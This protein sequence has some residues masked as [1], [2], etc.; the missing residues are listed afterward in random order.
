MFALALSAALI[1]AAACGSGDSGD[2][3][4]PSPER[5]PIPFT[6]T[7]TPQIKAFQYEIQEGDSLYGL[8]LRFNT[9]LEEIVSLNGINDVEAIGIGEVILIPGDPPPDLPSP[10]VTVIP[11]NPIGSGFLFPIGGACLP[12]T[13]N[14]MPNAPRVYRAGI[15]EGVD[16]YTGYNCAPVQEGT[17]VLAVKFGTIIRADHD[18]VEMTPEELDEALSRSKA[19]GYTDEEAL[20][21]FRGRQVWLDHGDGII[22][23]YSHLSDIPPEIQVRNQVEAGVVIGYAGESGTPEANT[24]PG[25]EMH[26]HFE[27]RVGGSFLGAGLPADQVRT[28]YDDVFSAP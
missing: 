23:R 7:P 4:T 15:H 18:F 22:T 17:P 13:D 26:L 20:D 8:A 10:A 3:A 12:N 27:I 11:R 24:K 1:L 2:E 25:T 6:S 14:L 21:R 9:T 19:Q 16:F 28:V 5:T